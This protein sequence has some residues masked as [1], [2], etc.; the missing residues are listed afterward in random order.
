MR[1]Y[2]RP[3]DAGPLGVQSRQRCLLLALR[4]EVACE[5]SGFDTKD[6]SVDTGWV[7]HRGA[8]PIFY[9]PHKHS[10]LLCNPRESE[11]S[12]S[13]PRWD[14]PPAWWQSGS[15]SWLSWFWWSKKIC[16]FAHLISK[17]AAFYLLQSSIPFCALP[18]NSFGWPCVL[19]SISELP[20]LNLPT[21]LTSSLDP[22]HFS[23]L[24]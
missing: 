18:S 3:R 16:H 10:T 8:C 5:P 23:R 22:T 13:W 9:G 14:F 17:H 1:L 4:V 21:F 2:G 20:R 6:L 24:S 7:E 11:S 12:S 15:E 19:R